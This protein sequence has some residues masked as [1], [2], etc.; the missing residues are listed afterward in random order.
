[1]W[2]EGLWT[3]MPNRSKGFFLAYLGHT[4]NWL[5]FG[6]AM[7]TRSLLGRPGG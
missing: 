7:A 2:G 4:H 6:E 1:M 5:H 3:E